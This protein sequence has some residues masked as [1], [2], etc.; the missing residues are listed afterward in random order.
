MQFVTTHVIIFFPN[1]KY[2]LRVHFETFRSG[3]RIMNRCIQ[4]HFYVALPGPPGTG[5]C[6]SLPSGIL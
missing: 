4:L 1:I 2:P 5:P 3:Y 6:R